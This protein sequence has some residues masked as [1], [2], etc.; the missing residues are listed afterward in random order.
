MVGAKIN[1]VRDVSPEKA[2]QKANTF[3]QNKGVRVHATQSHIIGEETIFFQYYE[4]NPIKEIVP[5][6]I[7][8]GQ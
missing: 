2:V 4:G 5:L 1:I 8:G 6:K 7:V 3:S